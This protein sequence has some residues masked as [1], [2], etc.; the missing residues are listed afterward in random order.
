MPV[1]EN[2]LSKKITTTKLMLF[3]LSVGGHYPEYIAHLINYWNE[4]KVKEKLNIVVSPLFFERH[5][6]VVNLAKQSNYSNVEF[7]T[8]SQRELANLKTFDTGINRNI[9]AWQKF[10]IMRNYAVKLKANHVFIPYFD[11]LQIPFL[12]NQNL[13]F[14]YSGIYFRPSFYYQHV[15][16][17][18]FSFK[19]RLQYWREKLT[20]TYILKKSHLKTLFC[21][22]PFAIKHINQLTNKPKAVYLSDPVQIHSNSSINFKQ[23]HSTLGIEAS[24]QAYLLFGGLGKRK[25]LDQLLESIA[26]LDAKLC[27]KLCILIVGAMTDDCFHKCLDTVNKLVSNLSVQIIIKN[28]YIPEEEIQSYFQLSDAILAPYQRHVGMS[29]IINRAAVAQK[30][31]LASSYGLMGE[32]T[33]R[34]HLGLAIDSTKPKEIAKGLTKFLTNSPDKYCDFESMKQY[35]EQNTPQKFAD[36]ILQHIL[37]HNK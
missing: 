14:T 2:F 20:L 9:R 37:K 22:D 30:P 23:L 34:H 24:R 5:K 16:D 13:P 31:V 18:Y 27:H 29:G 6:N 25:G 36:T 10:Q 17:N 33:R 4:K 21:L 32:L 26:L 11:T 3:E 12:F 28:E 1:K 8:I 7:I 35:A 15:D 19:D